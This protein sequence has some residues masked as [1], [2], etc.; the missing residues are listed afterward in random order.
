MAIG[1]N[2]TDI[3]QL[4][5]AGLVRKAIAAVEIIG[6]AMGALLF[7]RH[8]LNVGPTNPNVWRVAPLPIAAFTLCV[9]AGALLW[10]QTTV[11]RV[12]TLIAL[13]LQVPSVRTATL[14]YAFSVGIGFRVLVGSHGVSQFAFWGSELHL[15]L[16]EAAPHTTIGVN[17]V[18]L[19]FGVIVW[20]GRPR[21]RPRR[22]PV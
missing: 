12:L 19:A 14:G 11:G 1:R 7:L 15:T 16:R 6:G 10:R 22:G 8:A 20:A 17:I 3:V 9:V 21:G 13:A 4:S 5:E 18:A 2:V